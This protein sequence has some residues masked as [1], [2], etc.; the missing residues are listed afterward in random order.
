MARQIG[1]ETG[2]AK[3]KRMLKEQL[4]RMLIESQLFNEFQ[5]EVFHAASFTIVGLCFGQ[6]PVR[7]ARHFPPLLRK[8]QDELISLMALF[9]LDGDGV[10]AKMTIY[11]IPCDADGN[12]RI[13]KTD[14]TVCGLLDNHNL[15]TEFASFLALI[16]DSLKSYPMAI[17]DALE[18]QMLML[19]KRWA[20]D[21]TKTEK[22]ETVIRNLFLRLKRHA[23]SQL[24][25]MAANMLRNDG[26]F[27]VKGSPL[28]NLAA[29][30]LTSGIENRKNPPD[31]FHH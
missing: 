19:L 22:G 7:I 1:I 18:N 11:P 5:L 29:D 8:R 10:F 14:R 28:W 13:L 31:L 12:G 24:W 6:D 16:G 21:A 3:N 23:T 25:N 27:R 2:S 15:L 30:I 9:W 20:M 17:A 26:E 4:L